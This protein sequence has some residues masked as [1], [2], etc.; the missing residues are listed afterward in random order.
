MNYYEASIQ[1][2]F[3]IPMYEYFHLMSNIYCI[4]TYINSKNAYQ[5]NNNFQK[6]CKRE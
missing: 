5:K 3:V 4:A 1:N 2:L 6:L